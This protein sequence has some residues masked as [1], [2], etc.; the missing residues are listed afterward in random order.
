[1]KHARMIPVLA[2]IVVSLCAPAGAAII[3]EI[4]VNSINTSYTVASP[5]TDS[6]LKFTQS[7]ITVVL[8]WSDSVQQSVSG[9]TFSLVTYLKEDLSPNYAPGKAVGEFAGGTIVI[10]DGAGGTY[11][12]GDVTSMFLEE[13][14]VLPGTVL[15]GHGF[16]D[17]TGGSW[18]SN[19]PW[20][21]GEVFNITWVLSQTI[22]DFSQSFGTTADESDLTLIPEPGTMALLA[23]GSVGM[24]RRRRK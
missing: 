1:M 18:L 20:T 4:S 5:M 6:E 14:T 10:G 8:E 22:S 15:A 23:I 17:V 13:L 19:I 9:A 11:L 2:V 7:D 3:S 12:E 16:F 24:L 21:Q